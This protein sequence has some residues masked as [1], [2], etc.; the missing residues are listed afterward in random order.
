MTNQLKDT[1]PT[2]EVTTHC[3]PETGDVI[4][5]LPDELLE[6]MGW[7]EGDEVLFRQTADGR[8]VITKK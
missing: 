3:D 5:P 8:W 1:Q 6:R 4:L 7:R 2:F